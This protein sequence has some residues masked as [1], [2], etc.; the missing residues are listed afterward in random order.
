MALQSNF[1]PLRD[2]CDIGV[3]REIQSGTHSTDIIFVKKTTI[4][5]PLFSKGKLI[6]AVV[7]LRTFIAS[8]FTLDLLQVDLV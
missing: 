3:S 1:E 4:Y 8:R 6:L 7:T 5:S 2:S